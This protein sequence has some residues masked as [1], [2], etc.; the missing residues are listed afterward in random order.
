MKQEDSMSGSIQ[1]VGRDTLSINLK[2][3]AIDTVSIQ[4]TNDPGQVPCNPHHDTID[5]EVH[6]RAHGFVLIIK[7][8]VSSL[9][10]VSWKVTFA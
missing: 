1:V 6:D 8:D 7:W 3:A 9:R 2:R 10:E 4:F 5:W